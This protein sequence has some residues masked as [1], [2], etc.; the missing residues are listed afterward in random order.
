ME[1]HPAQ[2]L[3]VAVKGR[4]VFYSEHNETRKALVCE[5]SRRS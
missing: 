5:E 2:N 1:G 4:H 3:D